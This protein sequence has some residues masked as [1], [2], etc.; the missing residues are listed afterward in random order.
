MPYIHSPMF[1]TLSFT[2]ESTRCLVF[3]L[4]MVELPEVSEPTVLLVVNRP[5]PGVAGGEISNPLS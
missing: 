3:V 5:I 2:H 1:D 4:A